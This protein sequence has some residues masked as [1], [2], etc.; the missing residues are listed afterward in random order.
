MRR[1][2]ILGLMGFV[3]AIAFAFAALRGSNAFWSGGLLL[4]TL[5]L[6]GFAILASFR[7]R[8]G[9]LGFLVA[10]GGYFLAV[11]A[12]PATETAS[13]PTSLLL[14]YAQDRFVPPASITFNSLSLPFMTASPPTIPSTDP[15]ASTGTVNFVT[16]PS[17][18]WNPLAAGAPNVDSYRSIGQN[19]F[20]LLFG[21]LGSIVARR[22]R[23][24][25][26]IRHPTR[27]APDRP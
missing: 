19:L 9:W 4:V 23:S 7:G 20:A 11:R 18:T 24:Q 15:G 27:D 25:G 2:S 6:L 13:L 5:G 22:M 1:F 12:L 17:P 3:L 14:D 10:C 16:V 26:E 8:V 21:W